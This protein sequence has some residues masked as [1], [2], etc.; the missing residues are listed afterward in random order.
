MNKF[1]SKIL[2][3][4][5]FSCQSTFLVGMEAQPKFDEDID[6][7]ILVNKAQTQYLENWISLIKEESTEAQSF[8][9][10]FI[11]P[12]GGEK[13]GKQRAIIDF[14]IDYLYSK[15]I[16]S[17]L[18]KIK[19]L[20]SQELKREISS[21]IFHDSLSKLY[22]NI[23][24]AHDI[25][26]GDV[27]KR[28]SDYLCSKSDSI[29]VNFDTKANRRT[30]NCDPSDLVSIINVHILTSLGQEY[31]NLT[32]FTDSMKHIFH[33]D[34][35]TIHYFNQVL[36]FEKIS[37][38]ISE[39]LTSSNDKR[40][41][42]PA[43]G[44]GKFIYDNV[45]NAVI[46]DNT[47]NRNIM[48]LIALEEEIENGTK[49]NQT[50]NNYLQTLRSRYKRKNSVD[51]LPNE[52]AFIEQQLAVI[53]PS[54]KPQAIEKTSNDG[55]G[56]NSIM[57][58]FNKKNNRKPTPQKKQQTKHANSN[59]TP[60]KKKVIKSEVSATNLSA[61]VKPQIF[62]P[63]TRSEDKQVLDINTGCFLLNPSPP[64]AAEACSVITRHLDFKSLCSL[65]CTTKA[66]HLSFVEAREKIR[67]SEIEYAEELF[68]FDDW[69]RDNVTENLHKKNSM[70]Q[71]CASSR[72]FRIM[73][74]FYGLGETFIDVVF[75][76]GYAEVTEKH[77]NSF[78][79][80]AGGSKVKM[81][82]NGYIPIPLKDKSVE[83]HYVVPNLLG[84]EQELPFCLF[85]VHQ[86]HAASIPFPKKT[87]Y[88]FLRRDLAKAGYAR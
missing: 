66:L 84:T 52:S 69:Y 61:I 9:E 65:I 58:Q 53:F 16:E 39:C 71:L 15:I 79:K 4:I 80:Q 48:L 86:P 62:L 24:R 63:H 19:N 75:G 43:I 36:N 5:G 72:T 11:F 47:T 77:F 73:P 49:L 78:L 76:H 35:V 46:D 22:T 59:I 54:N 81:S 82:Q 67:V 31:K 37:D 10:N 28:G 20:K 17:S 30:F 87:L 3:V 45:Y 29:K 7:L 57:D 1:L 50:Q 83:T 41:F 12:I 68:D 74:Q 26:I 6:K 23:R 42:I 33:D 32:A 25:T 21:D 85:L 2:L 64:Y 8:L 88:S 51:Y 13:L 60:N 40:Y 55:W 38:Y 56:S 27:V 18:V 44:K 14:Y 34:P 70:I